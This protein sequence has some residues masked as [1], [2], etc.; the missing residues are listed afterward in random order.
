MVRCTDSYPRTQPGWGL[1]SRKYLSAP[2][3]HTWQVQVWDRTYVES[4]ARSA[5][6][7]SS[8]AA[9][10]P[11][12]STFFGGLGLTS[13]GLSIASITLALADKLAHGVSLI[14]SP[15]LLLT[16]MLFIIGVQLVLMGF[17]AEISVRTYHKSQAKPTY[18]VRRIVTRCVMRETGPFWSHVSRITHQGYKLLGEPSMCGICGLVT[19]RPDREVKEETLHRMCGAMRHRG[20][21]D[22]GIFIEDG[23]GI[24]MRR[25]SIID[26]NSGH[27]PIHNED[28]TIWLVFNGEII[29]L[30]GVARRVAQAGTQFLYTNGH[31]GG[32]A[33]LRA[34]GR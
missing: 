7:S 17:L 8:W 2:P 22:E 33:C 10:L 31:R 4:G 3:A 13:I 16:A 14:Q 19:F 21:D 27:Q 28:R 12:L 6:R 20:P 24:G 23:V 15:L 1:L 11:S 18:V 29:Q 32:G 9:I 26:L 30:S 34:V 25:L 5:R